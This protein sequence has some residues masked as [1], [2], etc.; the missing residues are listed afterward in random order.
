MQLTLKRKLAIGTTVVAAAAFAGGAYA[1]TQDSGASSRQAF[2]NDVAK[3][4]KVT[5]QQLTAALQGA[6][7]DQLAAAVSARK[8]T[9]AQANAIKN[10]VQQRGSPLIGGWHWF[11]PHG[12]QAPGGGPPP[13]GAPRAFG[14]GG[15]RGFGPAG[16]SSLSAAAKYL[17]L[18]DV[19]LSKE[20]VSGKSLAQIAQSRGNSTTGMKD[21]MI[22]AIR[23]R[24]DKVRAA[25]LLTSA[26]EQ[27]ILS[28]RS[29]RLDQEINRSGLA[30][31]RFF[32][33]RDGI[34]PVLIP[35]VLGGIRPPPAPPG[36]P[37]GPAL[38]Y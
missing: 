20:L 8:L 2:L 36:Q 34:V 12:L 38:A 27:M 5:P 1:A 22:A 15:A 10:R 13:F 32:R 14:P 31:R 4:L 28:E 21:A 18:T 29:A 24:L 26:Q 30:Q 17:G 11:G 23:A 7:F 25:N 19:Q 35:G 3:R 16:P 37:S 6:F 9:Q 33:G